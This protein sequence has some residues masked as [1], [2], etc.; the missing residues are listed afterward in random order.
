MRTLVQRLQSQGLLVVADFGVE[1]PAEGWRMW[2]EKEV[3]AADA[4]LALVDPA[5]AATFGTLQLRWPG[6]LLTPA[7]CSAQVPLRPILP[8]GFDETD[9]IHRP[10]ELAHQTFYPVGTEQDLKLLM[11]T[12]RGLAQPA[13]AGE[14]T[15]K[16]P[17]PPR[18]TS[19]LPSLEHYLARLQARV[20]FHRRAWRYFRSKL[21]AIGITLEETGCNERGA[22]KFAGPGIDLALTQYS[23]HAEAQLEILPGTAPVYASLLGLVAGARQPLECTYLVFLLHPEWQLFHGPDFTE[24]LARTDIKAPGQQALV[25]HGWRFVIPSLS[26]PESHGTPLK[27]VPRPVYPW[28]LNPLRLLLHLLEKSGALHRGLPTST[29]QN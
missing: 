17:A 3:A 26:L 5:Y 27:I 19:P 9:G 8:V 7:L 25:L 13:D 12:L 22:Q 15:D 1:A 14:Q 20:Q 18:I 6:P 16:E 23:E 24:R 28:P 21:E 4:V 10:G 29:F 11:R 2:V